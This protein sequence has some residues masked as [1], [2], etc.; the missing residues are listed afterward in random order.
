MKP[1]PCFPW[2]SIA[3]SD[4]GKIPLL[5]HSEKGF[6]PGMGWGVIEGNGDADIGKK[7]ILN[8][9]RVSAFVMFF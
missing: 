8:T 1:Q 5:L 4:T 6:Q 9:P 7:R 2:W 3:V